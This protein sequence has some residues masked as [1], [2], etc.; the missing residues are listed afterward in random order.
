MRNR[1]D[2][3]YVVELGIEDHLNIEHLIQLHPSVVMTYS[4]GNDLGSLKKVKEL[5]IPVVINAEFLEQHP[6]GRAEWIKFM[7]L[8]FEKELEADSIFN[9]IE[10]EYINLQKQ[11]SRYKVKPTVLTG[12]PYGGVWFLPGG[13]NYGARFFEDAGC[14]YLW[15]DDPTGGFLKLSL[16]SVFDKALNA[17]YWIGVGSFE[18]YQDLKSFDNR[19]ANFQAFQNRKVFNYNNRIGATGG[20]EY[21]ELGYLRPDLVLKDLIQITHPEEYPTPQLY[22]YKAIK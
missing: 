19:F 20:N 18:T 10:N 14:H 12:I 9:S 6:L 22:F 13:Q 21:L 4:A 16:E 2:S 8:F 1:V 7:A 15:S 11:A 5:G 3:G 17:D